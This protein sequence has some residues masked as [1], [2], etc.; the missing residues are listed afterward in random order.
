MEIGNEATQFHFLECINRIF[1][2]VY[3]A[4]ACCKASPSSIL[5]SA[6][7]KMRYST[8]NLLRKLEQVQVERSKHLFAFVHCTENIIYVF[9]E[10][11]L[12]DLSHSS[13]IHVSVSDLYIP[14][15][16]PHIW[17]QQNRQT[18]P[19]NI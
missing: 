19:E 6:P 2:V 14:R 9:P 12:C 13:Y 17:L 15:I 8:V 5:G 10:K 18:D 3:S 4:S 11:E 16:S 1:F 7:Q